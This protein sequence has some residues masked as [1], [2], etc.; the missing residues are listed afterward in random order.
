MRIRL[1]LQLLALLLLSCGASSSRVST[2]QAGDIEV[3]FLDVGQGDSTLIKC[4]NGRRI[5]VDCG[6]TSSPAPDAAAIAADL[7]QH[8]DATSPVID[9]LVVTHP[10]ADHYNQLTKVLVGISVKRILLP[11][12]AEDQEGRDD[13]INQYKV[14]K[15]NE[16][17]LARNQ[18]IRWVD[19]EN[20]VKASKAASNLFFTSDND[21]KFYILAANVGGDGGEKNGRSIVLKVTFKEFDLV[22]TGD[23]TKATENHILGKYSPP[24]DD[25]PDWLDIDFLK[26]GHHGSRSTS[27]QPNWL[28]RLKPEYAM[29]SAGAD[30]RY[31]HPN[32]D[33]V[34]RVGPHLLDAPPHRIMQS[35]G[36]DQPVLEVA[37]YAKSLWVTCANGKIRLTSAGQDKAA[38][39]S[40]DRN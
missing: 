17:L 36:K 11:G 1:P 5:L 37:G 3:V 29:A 33:I 39:V 14:S 16:W 40:V 4:P 31:G 28:N 27:S 22:L 35:A 6:S 21:A 15:F 2:R 8:L 9:V 24:D 38:V 18:D 32:N 30:N 12:S 26:L 34:S 23:A 20:E 10:D 13:L 19:A 25:A 7:K